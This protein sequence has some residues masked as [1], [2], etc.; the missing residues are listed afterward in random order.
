M[1]NVSRH[2]RRRSAQ[3]HVT[4]RAEGSVVMC[5]VIDGVRLDPE[6]D[7]LCLKDI[8]CVFANQRVSLGVVFL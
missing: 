5:Y 2:R 1:L 7:K 3:H 4:W 6:H 8:I